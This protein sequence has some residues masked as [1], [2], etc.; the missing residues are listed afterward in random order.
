MF[1]VRVFFP[2]DEGES[3]THDFATEAQARD[4]IWQLTE[5]DP[6]VVF[7]VFGQT[8]LLPG[9]DDHGDVFRFLKRRIE[10]RNGKKAA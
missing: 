5:A 3:E 9:A 6:S 1:H 10:N 2:T 8:Q 4:F 7:D